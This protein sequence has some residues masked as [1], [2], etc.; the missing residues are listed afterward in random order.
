[1]YKDENEGKIYRKFLSNISNL[2][3]YS[4]LETKT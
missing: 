4:Y 2:H 1:M 3:T